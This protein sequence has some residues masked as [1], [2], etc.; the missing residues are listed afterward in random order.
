M[1]FDDRLAQRVRDALAEV[2]GVSE[3]QKFGGLAFLVGGHM[4]TATSEAT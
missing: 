3:R 1:A 4:A 2:P